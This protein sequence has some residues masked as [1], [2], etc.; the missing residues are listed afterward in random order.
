MPGVYMYIYVWLYRSQTDWPGTN[1]TVYD[2]IQHIVINLH[3]FVHKANILRVIESKNCLLN[4]KLLSYGLGVN[5]H[6]L[7]GA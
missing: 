6:D 5:C 4:V 3:L 1:Y 2:N 7:V